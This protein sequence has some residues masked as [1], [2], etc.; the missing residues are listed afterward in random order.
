V[1]QFGAVDEATTIVLKGHLL[2]E[3]ALDGIISNFVFHADPLSEA[4]L[5]FSQ[6]LHLARS[7]SVR[8]SENSMWRLG[9]ALNALRNELAHNLDSPRRA[10]KLKALLDAYGLET[11]GDADAL[12]QA[13][14]PEPQAIMMVCAYFVGFLASFRAEVDQ[15]RD[16]VKAH[17][18]VRDHADAAQA[19]Q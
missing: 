8:E 10:A 11:K 18:A 19:K 9:T 2:I 6:K 17:R 14:L 3:E 12:K 13:D 1:E 4:R 16:M 7:M 5:S 15:F